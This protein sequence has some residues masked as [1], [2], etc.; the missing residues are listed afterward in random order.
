MEN[1]YYWF[2]DKKIGQ[3][4]SLLEVKNTQK[5]TSLPLFWHTGSSLGR[6]KIW[7]GKWAPNSKIPVGLESR[8]D[9]FSKNPTWAHFGHSQVSQNRPR[10]SVV[11]RGKIA[12]FASVS[13]NFDSWLLQVGLLIYTFVFWHQR[14][15]L[16]HFLSIWTSI[17]V[18]KEGKWS[19]KPKVMFLALHL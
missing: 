10:S 19:P 7:R 9:R 18:A 5:R 14:W 2:S 11:H 17:Q 15:H 13:R 4:L 1:N 16:K 3:D 12:K 8:Q 6:M